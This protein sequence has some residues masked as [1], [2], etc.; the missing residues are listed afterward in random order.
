MFFYMSAAETSSQKEREIDILS[1]TSTAAHTMGKEDLNEKQRSP[2]V[3]GCFIATAAMGSELHPHVQLLRDFRD[4]ILLQSRYK[5]SFENML[6]H[7]Y[8]FS[9][10]IAR[11]MQRHTALKMGL[12]YTLVYPIV[13][14]IRIILPVMNIILGIERDAKRRR[15]RAQM[16]S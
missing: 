1:S 13:F 11:T 4:N 14:G 2:I 3:K 10:P 6:D 9:P 16:I 8:R 5:K 15:R 7:Y 12:R